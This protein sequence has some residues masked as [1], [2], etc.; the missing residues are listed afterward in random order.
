MVIRALKRLEDVKKMVVLL[1]KALP[2]SKKWG[3]NEKKLL[4]LHLN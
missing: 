2:W 4:S 3:E 1:K